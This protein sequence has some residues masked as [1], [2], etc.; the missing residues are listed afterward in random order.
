MSA[1]I[2]R[3]EQLLHTSTVLLRVCR[4]HMLWKL[5]PED[6]LFFKIKTICSQQS[7]KSPRIDD[8]HASLLI[9]L[10]DKNYAL[11]LRKACIGLKLSIV[12]L[13][14]EY[15]EKQGIDFD[16][17][18]ASVSTGKTALDM[19]LESKPS[20]KTGQGNKAEIIKLLKDAGAQMAKE[21]AN[22]E[23]SMCI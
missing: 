4:R 15:K 3:E 9:A 17:N 23:T 22:L 5:C 10:R 14:L 20:S 11:T 6:A 18:E 1:K 8:N 7:V 19:V 12:K 2:Q 21:S 13:L 16:L